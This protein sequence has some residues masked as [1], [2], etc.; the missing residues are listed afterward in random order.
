MHCQAINFQIG[1]LER[2]YTVSD[3][4][5]AFIL[6]SSKRRRKG[7]QGYKKADDKEPK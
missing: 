7:W 3:D 2:N 4:L 5:Q 6:F 1:I